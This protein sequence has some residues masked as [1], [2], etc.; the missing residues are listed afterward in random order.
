MLVGRLDSLQL[1]HFVNTF[2]FVR[3]CV[4]WCACN[5]LTGVGRFAVFAWPR[6]AEGAGGWRIARFDGLFVEG[7]VRLRHRSA[8]ASRC[9]PGMLRCAP[10]AQDSRRESVSRGRVPLHGGRNIFCFFIPRVELDRR[11]VYVAPMEIRL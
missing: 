2:L 4:S 6:R 8:L 7:F 11:A 1:V 3:L 9:S 10:I 5:A